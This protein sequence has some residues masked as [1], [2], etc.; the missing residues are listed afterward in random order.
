MTRQPEPALRAQQKEAAVSNLRV[1]DDLFEQ[2]LPDRFPR[3]QSLY[4]KAK[5]DFWNESTEIDWDQEIELEPDKRAAL[6]RLLSI[7]YYGE[8][9]ALTIAGQLVGMVPDEEAKQALACQ[10]VEEAKHVGAFQKLLSRLD[11]IHPPSFFARRLL[12]DLIKTDDPAAKM[13]GMHLFVE[14]IANH[15]FRALHDHIDEPLTRSVLD[16]VARDERK[17]TAIA[18]LYLPK[19][20]KELNPLQVTALQVKQIKWLTL[21]IGMVKDGY[22]DARVLNIDLASAGQKALKDHYRLRNA[23]ETTRGLID[24]PYFDRAIDM[25]GSWA[26]A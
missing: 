12:T 26:S 4:E 10:V 1:P 22:A 16:Y 2:K 5:K 7:T 15:S 17:H 25:I 20:L 13:T 6:A 11:R 21:G 24:V 3:L 19:L 8:R 14:N 23:M 18:V 9:A